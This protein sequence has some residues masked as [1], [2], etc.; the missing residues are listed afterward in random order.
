MI[1]PDFNNTIYPILEE[2]LSRKLSKEE[3]ERFYWTSGMYKEWLFKRINECS[4][5]EEA[6][7]LFGGF[8]RVKTVQPI[9][10]LNR[11]LFYIQEKCT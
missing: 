9:G 4:T 3:N 11:I 6:E 1:E 10:L 8:R 5:L 2:K 7:Q